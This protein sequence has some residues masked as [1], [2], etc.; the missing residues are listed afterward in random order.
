MLG[1]DKIGLN[2]RIGSKLAI[3][4]GIGVLLMAAIIVSQ[5]VG[6][7]QIRELSTTVQRTMP[8]AWRKS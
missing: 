8:F 4:S 3:T 7:S 2:L 5:L 6:N 1:L